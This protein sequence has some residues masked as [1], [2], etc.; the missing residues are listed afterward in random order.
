VIVVLIAGVAAVVAL[1]LADRPPG[2]SAPA[3]CAE[4][5]AAQDLDEGLASLDPDRLD[6]QVA[7]LA[8]AHAVAPLEIEPTI[9]AVR[10]LVEDL[11]DTIDAAP[12]DR[13]DAVVE[14]LR[15]REA[16]LP[17]ARFAGV[18]LEDYAR[19][20]CSLELSTARPA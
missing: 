1:R 9:A 18:V 20:T 12:G 15:A 3:F 7:A 10:D 14:A 8:R 17:R 2:R 4:L 5:A 16:D 13:V 19:N 11:R 6:P